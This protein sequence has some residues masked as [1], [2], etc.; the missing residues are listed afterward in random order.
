MD[1]SVKINLF[2]SGLLISGAAAHADE[3]PDEPNDAG[4]HRDE[5]DG[6]DYDGEVFSYK[7]ERPEPV[8]SYDEKRHPCHPSGDIVDD[9]AAVVHAAHP[10]HERRKGAHDGHEAGYDYR[11]ASIFFEKGARP[12]EVILF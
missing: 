6:E 1:N 11:F 3:L 8:A 9:E 4:Q 5:D 12:V 10:C 2:T 7:R